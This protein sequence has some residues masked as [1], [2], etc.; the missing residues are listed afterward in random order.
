MILIVLCIVFAKISND[1]F[2]NL[3]ERE[4]VNFK[5]DEDIEKNQAQGN[6]Q[7]E[8]EMVEQVQRK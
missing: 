7:K 1:T 8:N 6:V 2:D 3:V 4:F 5:E